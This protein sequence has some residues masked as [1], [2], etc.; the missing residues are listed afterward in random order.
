MDVPLVSGFYGLYRASPPPRYLLSQLETHVTLQWVELKIWKLTKCSKFSVDYDSC[1]NLFLPFNVRNVLEG[2]SPPIND[3][4][5]KETKHKFQRNIHI[6]MCRQYLNEFF[7]LTAKLGIFY[8]DL[9]TNRLLVPS[10]YRQDTSVHGANYIVGKKP[11][12]EFLPNRFRERSM[13][14]SYNLKKIFFF[15]VFIPKSTYL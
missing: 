5:D 6:L 2:L 15:W 1:K 8:V 11:K 4:G 13:P 14:M 7:K 10:N 3:S 9:T 12:Q